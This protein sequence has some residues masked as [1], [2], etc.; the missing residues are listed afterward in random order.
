MEMEF[1]IIQLEENLEDNGSKIRKMGTGSFNMLI[2]TGTKV[3][4]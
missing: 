2:M 1:T 3:I 4:G